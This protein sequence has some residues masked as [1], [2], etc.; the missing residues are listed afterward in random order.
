MPVPGPGYSITVRLEAPPSA[1]AA[2]DLTSAVGRAGGVITAFDVVESHT[3]R[4]IID[5]TCNALSANHAKD[6]TDTL[7]LLPGIVVRKVSDRTFLVHLGGKIE[8]S[9]K[10]PLRNRDD[11]SRA[12]TP[13]VAR[14]CQA[15]AENP[16][17]A[18]RLTIKRNTV[19]VVTDGSAVLGLGNLGPAAALP[20]M[21]GKAALFKKFAGVDAWPVCL[22]TQDTEEIIRAVELIAP[23]YGGIN[24][25]DIAAPRCFEI[26]ARLRE[27]L[28]IPV[29]HDDQH[30]TA[31]VVVGALRNALRVVGK[32]LADC[33]VVVCGVGAAGSAIIRLL[34]KQGP[35]DVVA[36]DVDGIVHRD[37]PG[38]DDN[39]KSIAA[40]TNK[41]NVSG[42][43]HDALVGADV[44]IGVSAPNLFGADQ[45]ATMNSDAIVFAL[46]NPDPEIDPMEAQKHAAVVATGRSDFPN[47]INN[48]LAFPGVFR[49]LLDAHARTITD[50]MLLAAA[51]AIA[52][53][54]DG[55]KLNA[56]FIVPSVFDTS[57]AP[58][59]AEAVRKAAVEQA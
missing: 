57:V 59:V 15:I 6:I 29:F 14:V 16:D 58:A 19:A 11:L 44:F 51:N 42:R 45:V 48:V 38:L 43:L 4:V 31:I 1:S 3:D 7:E 49:G 9:S 8:I 13:G 30:G 24:L 28:D 37:R 21:E 52:D 36:V 33:K 56:S 40:V 25:E 54:V 20:V 22:D 53:V 32:K 2:G 18:R 27:K 41:D 46:A 34:L 26:E 47:Q 55:E 50:A 17:D 12:Y 35:G 5:L 23:V 39:L 10:V